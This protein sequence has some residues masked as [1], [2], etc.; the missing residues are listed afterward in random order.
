MNYSSVQLSDK[1]YRI[2]SEFNDA[3][4]TFDVVVAESDVEIPALVEH[5]LECLKNPIT[6]YSEASNQNLSNLQDT[7]SKQNDLI[8][9]LE[10]RLAAL[11]AK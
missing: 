10:Q 2:T 8:A 3:P 1:T 7:V 5:H 4:I 11:E 9:A 6:E